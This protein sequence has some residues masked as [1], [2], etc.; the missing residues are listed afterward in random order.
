MQ[1]QISRGSDEGN[2]I[3][4]H[5][6]SGGRKSAAASMRARWMTVDLAPS[7]LYSGLQSEWH[8][9]YA[10]LR[11]GAASANDD[12]CWIG[13]RSK[14]CSCCCCCCWKPRTGRNSVSLVAEV[15]SA[16]VAEMSVVSRSTVSR[17]KRRSGWI[18]AKSHGSHQFESHA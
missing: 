17:R 18:A 9:G 4:G 14:D 10:M 7:C 16:V 12:H 6:T 11:A 15:G 5:A 13:N 3:C 2:R 8:C 1:Q